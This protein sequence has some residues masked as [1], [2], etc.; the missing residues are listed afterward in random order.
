MHNKKVYIVCSVRNRTKEEENRI[1]TYVLK[2]EQQDCIVRCPFRDTDQ[3][4]EIGLRITEEH[5]E[6]IIWA[7][8]IHIIW[9][10]DSQG[11]LWDFAQA[12][13][14]K[15]FMP[16]KKIILSNI[17]EIEI[18]KDNKGRIIKSYTNVLIATHLGLNKNTGGAEFEKIKCKK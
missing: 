12:R 1:L 17:D 7:D 3:N 11:S 9:N 8:E 2:L 4:D 5:E 15:R 14:A 13:M 6:D 10:P 18:T 16:E